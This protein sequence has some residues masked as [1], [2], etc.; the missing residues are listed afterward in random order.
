[1]IETIQNKIKKAITEW[2]PNIRD[3]VN[4]QEIIVI[5]F[6]LQKV[7]D[8]FELYLSG[9]SWYDDYDLWVLDE[10]WT[11]NYNYIPLGIDS[12]KFDR[13]EILEI[14]TVLLENE[15]RK[16][17]DLYEKLIV[18]VGLVDGDPKRLK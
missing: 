11:P 17:K 4:H 9:H 3:L 14:Y 13:L 12:L 5:N 2:N 15:I 18:F 16:S 1:M 6:G 10:E 7:Y 8:G